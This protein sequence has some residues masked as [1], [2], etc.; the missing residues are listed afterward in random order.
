MRT[1]EEHGPIRGNRA[2]SR[3]VDQRQ[4]PSGERV[5]EL[6]LG[7]VVRIDVCHQRSHLILMI[8]QIRHRRP[9]GV[10]TNSVSA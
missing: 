8:L 1:L 5:A 3:F 10:I 9:F 7:L 6:L 2:K 4:L